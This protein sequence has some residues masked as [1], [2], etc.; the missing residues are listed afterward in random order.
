MASMDRGGRLATR[1]LERA[2]ARVRAWPAQ[3]LPVL[4]ALAGLAATLFVAA[5]LDQGRQ[6]RAQLRFNA[7]VDQA[8]AAVERRLETYVEMLRAGS[9]L[10]AAGVVPAGILA[11]ALMVTAYVVARRR[12]YAS[13]PFPGFGAVA[14]RLVA[15]IPGLL[16]VGIIF[17][18]IRAGIFTAVE[19]ASKI[20]AASS[21]V[22]PEPPTSSRI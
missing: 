18:G 2:I 1:F 7:L 15:A 22:R 12:G 10:F 11:V 19:S 5:A 9:G 4:V 3:A 16:L 6:A 8:N 21:R 17:G 20:R 13:D 14:T